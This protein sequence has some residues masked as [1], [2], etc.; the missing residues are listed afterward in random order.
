MIKITCYVP[1]ADGAV[2]ELTLCADGGKSSY[3]TNLNLKG[4]ENR[5]LTGVDGLQL[6]QDAERLFAIA[7]FFQ[8]SRLLCTFTFKNLVPGDE[9][10]LPFLLMTRMAISS[11]SSLLGNFPL[12]EEFSSAGR[13]ACLD[14]PGFYFG[15]GDFT[16]SELLEN[17]LRDNPPKGPA[18][19]PQQPCAEARS[20]ASLAELYGLPLCLRRVKVE[21]PVTDCEKSN[22]FELIS[23]TG[24][25]NPAHLLGKGFT[26]DEFKKV[27]KFY[28]DAQIAT[29]CGSHHSTGVF[30]D[31]QGDDGVVGESYQLSLAIGDRIV[32]GLDFPPQGR[33]IASGTYDPVTGVVGPVDFIDAKQQIIKGWGLCPNDQ[34]LIATAED[35][36][37][38]HLPDY[39]RY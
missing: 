37:S 30:I 29:I 23:V 15:T 24:C 9:W 18:Y 25:S 20:V 39:T 7:S 26:N 6:W 31:Y 1:K 4:P 17:N 33:I 3:K 19:F 27:F 2:G 38:I 11:P 36:T 32:R 28:Y 12:T 10:H 13:L 5:K 35:H 14:T 34:V 16:L 21:F 22:S 8:S